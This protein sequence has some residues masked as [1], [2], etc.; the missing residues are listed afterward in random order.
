MQSA[1]GMVEVNSIPSGIE[2]GDAMLKAAAVELVAAQTACAGKYI[3]IVSGEVAAVKSSVESGRAIAAE[4]VVDSII[5]PS[6]YTQVIQAINACTE[7]KQSGALGIIETFSLSSAILAA[8]YA[9]KTADVELIEV[10][11]GR[12]LGGKSFV[13]LTGAVSAVREATE[14]AEKGEGTEGMIARTVVIPSPHPELLKA[15]Y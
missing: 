5:I 2:A 15:I 11:L 6:I 13:I 14:A 4:T 1:L 10:R 3:V 8:D 12:G 7:I 9:V